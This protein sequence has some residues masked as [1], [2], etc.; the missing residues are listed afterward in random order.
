MIAKKRNHSKNMPKELKQLNTIIILL[1][2]IIVILAFKEDNVKVDL[3]Y[4]LDVFDRLKC[5]YTE[6]INNTE[7]TY[8]VTFTN[9]ADL[10]AF[11][12]L[13][14][15]KYLNCEEIKENPILI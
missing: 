10:E 13:S 3:N 5:S 12:K 14:E 1:L 15:V 2:I 9:Y 6:T 4:K 8:Y 7:E 11:Q